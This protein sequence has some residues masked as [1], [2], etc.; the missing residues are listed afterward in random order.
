MKKVI[1]GIALL[2]QFVY[3]MDRSEEFASASSRG[4][5]NFVRVDSS[6]TFPLYGS[7]EYSALIGANDESAA[8]GTIWKFI[9]GLGGYNTE[10]GKNAL[11]TVLLSHKYLNA[12]I[13]SNNLSWEH[14]KSLVDAESNEDK[15]AWA[16]YS[17]FAK[18]LIDQHD[19][20][21]ENLIRNLKKQQKD[22]LESIAMQYN[23]KLK[24]EGETNEQKE[25]L[26]QK[27]IDELTALK[28]RLEKEKELHEHVSQ[29]F[30][31]NPSLKPEEIMIRSAEINR[32]TDIFKKRAAVQAEYLKFQLFSGLLGR[33]DL[34][35]NA[36]QD[37]L[38]KVSEY[39]NNTKVKVSRQKPA[40]P[41]LI[42][43][44]CWQQHRRIFVFPDRAFIESKYRERLNNVL[45]I[46]GFVYWYEGCKDIENTERRNAYNNAM[47]A[48]NAEVSRASAVS[49]PSEEFDRLV[50]QF[51]VFVS[52][53]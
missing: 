18:A 14:L 51:N 46:H 11:N 35:I 5:E 20:E 28:S 7:E 50:E 22:I 2:S 10:T 6:R 23:E 37:D 45:K 36:K 52:K 9:R 33:E 4:N 12:L 16:V 21:K 49:L 40:E 48:W 24:R 39:L 43:D 8:E 41:T 3:G 25:S 17:A 31:A 29:V 47:S 13:N 32:M 19:N 53:L 44:A 27:T 1:L 42:R 15:K 26:L 38:T 30:I 34:G